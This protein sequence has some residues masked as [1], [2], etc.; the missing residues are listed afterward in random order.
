[1]SAKVSNSTLDCFLLFMVSSTEV[2]RLIHWAD[3]ACD[4]KALHGRLSWKRLTAAQLILW[5]D[6]CGTVRESSFCE[7]ILFVRGVA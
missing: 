4:I 1:M 5:G 3:E 7:T 6:N 2:E